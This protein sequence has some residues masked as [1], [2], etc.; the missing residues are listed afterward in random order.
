M[1]SS[2]KELKIKTEFIALDAALKFSGI[3]QSGG[4]A[5]VLVLEDNVYV[6]GEVCRMRGKKL[7][8]GDKFE[9][10]GESFI[11]I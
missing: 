10:M 3:A 9:A 2:C 5:K 6:N 8:R 1:N 7:H 4:E 11:I